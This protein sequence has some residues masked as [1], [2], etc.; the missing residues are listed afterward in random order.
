MYD[1]EHNGE[2]KSMKQWADEL[3]V[4]YGA[5]KWRWQHGV[6]RFDSLFAG[7]RARNPL[8]L[9]QA[10]IEWLE[11]TR[12]ARK[13]MRDEWEIACELV[14]LSPYRAEELKQYMEGRP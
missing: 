4:N 7:G 8:R 10:D 14:G 2:V 12:K 1:I 3:G 13:G 9:T 5:V 11:F 6:R